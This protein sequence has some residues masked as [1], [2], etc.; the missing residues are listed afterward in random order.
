MK[1]RPYSLNF[2]E[3]T[4][5]GDS[6]LDINV[7][8]LEEDLQVKKRMFTTIALQRGTTGEEIADQVLDALRAEGVDPRIACLSAQTDAVPCSELSMVLTST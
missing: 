1:A 4:V 3:S 2:D 6:Q 7:S 8:Y 5:N